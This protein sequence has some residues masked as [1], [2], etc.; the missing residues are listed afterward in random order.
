MIENSHI[1]INLKALMNN[2]DFIRTIIGDDTEFV[3]V[4]K[5]NAYGHGIESFVPAAHLCGVNS[6]AVF[7]A[8]EAKQILQLGL[9]LDRIMIMGFIDEDQLAW[10]IENGIE[11][12]I[13]DQLTL[14]QAVHTSRKLKRK[15]KIHLE[16]ETGLN[17]T[18]IDNKGLKSV[19]GLISKSPDEIELKGVCSHLAGAENIANYYRIK[20]QIS[21]FNQQLKKLSKNGISAEKAHL[22]C[23]AAI[24]NY[25]NTISNL[26]RVGIMQYGFWPSK[27]VRMAYLVKKR[28]MDNPLKPV[29]SWKSKIMSTKAVKI[30]EYIGYG[31]S[32]QAE[33]NMKIATVPVGYA[34]GFARSLSNQG[35]VL[36][37]EQRLD[38][39][40]TV[41]MNLFIVD[42]TNVPEAKRGSEVTLIGQQGDSSISVAS[43]SDFSNQ[44]N[45]ELLTRLPRNIPRLI[46]N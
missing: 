5:G 17:R 4:V 1:E 33:Q 3:S 15:A 32:Q 45:Y 7:S 24:I 19:F 13:Y 27:E 34:D 43:F 21:K 8:Y 36:I 41:N 14:L 18:G 29:L 37:H 9:Q 46:T 16:L 44:L 39:I 42:I 10:T 28:V 23:S 2:L 35:K 11:F 6:F 26:V 40:G 12:Y 38:V 25:P 20:K 31:S 22:A 30:G